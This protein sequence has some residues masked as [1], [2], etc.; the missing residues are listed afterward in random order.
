MSFVLLSILTGCAPSGIWMITIPYV[1]GESTEDLCDYSLEENFQ[2]GDAPDDEGGGVD[3]EWEITESYVGSDSI[4]FL[5][6]EPVSGGGAVLLVGNTAYPGVASE[7]GWTFEWAVDTLAE[8]SA[9]HEDGYE[10]SASESNV[11]TTTID[12]LL[13]IFGEATGTVG[14][15]SRYKAEWTESDEWD[16]QDN[17][18][19]SG[20]IPSAV[21]LEYR[22]EGQ[23]FPQQNDPAE[24]DCAESLCKITIENVCP[25]SKSSFTAKHVDADDAN[26]YDSWIDN[27]QSGS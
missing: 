27:G 3:S 11:V 24:E 1:E 12:F 17:D 23:T 2:D 7:G 8:Y 15:S 13:P 4:M 16:P 10:Y 18:M 26:I 14:G 5:H 9:E 22:K 6:T 19:L 25:A 20:Q 21:Y